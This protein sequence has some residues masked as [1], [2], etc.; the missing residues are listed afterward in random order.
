MRIRSVRCRVKNLEIYMRFTKVFVRFGILLIRQ[1]VQSRLTNHIADDAI[2][3]VMT[4]SCRTHLHT[5]TSRY[6]KNEIT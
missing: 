1:S 5:C 6:E 3:I 4:P 2:N